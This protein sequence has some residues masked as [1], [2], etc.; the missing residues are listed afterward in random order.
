MSCLSQERPGV[1]LVDSAGVVPVDRPE[2]GVRGVVVL[3]FELSLE[4]LES[5]L[6]IDFFLNDVSEGEFDV[7]WERVVPA[8]VSR[9][10]VN[11][12]VSK[13]VVLAGEDHLEELVVAESL[14]SIAVEEAKEGVEL[15]L[16]YVIDLVVSKEVLEFSGRELEGVVSVKSLE[17]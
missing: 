14:V 13:V 9:W 12:S 17:G 6:E 15:S 4:S 8:Y 10:A 7:S 2:G 3:N 1:D 11:G 5:S 16:A